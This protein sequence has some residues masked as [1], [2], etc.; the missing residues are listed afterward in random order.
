MSLLFSP[1]KIGNLEIK[2][3]FIHSAT[4]EGMAAE[5][6]TVQDAIIK[7]YARLAKGEVGLIIPGYLFIHPHG[8]ALKYQT[9]IHSDEMIPGLKKVVDAV[10]E[11]DGRIVFQIAHSGRQTTKELIGR[12]PKGPSAKWRNP[13]DFTRPLEMKEAEIHKTIRDFG[14]AARR[15]A[16]AGADGV[17]L[18]AAH[19]YLINQFLS[20]FYNDR[21]DD[22]GG[23]DENR[24]RFLK[25]VMAEVRSALPENMPVLIKLN[26]NDFTPR[27][28]IV[29]SLAATYARWLEDLK[30]DLVEVSCGSVDFAPFNECRGDI[31]VDEMAACF[32]WWKR[33]FV[34]ALLNKWVGKYDLEEGYNLEAAECIKP[35][36]GR[37]PMSVVG[38]IRRLNQMEEIITNKKSDFLSMSRP[39][40]R[41]PDIVRKFR[42]NK[43]NAVACISCN[44]CVAAILYHLPTRCY[45]KGLPL[46]K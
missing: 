23:S 26:S 40:I 2:N 20:P 18:H 45:Q 39:F 13:V 8:Q 15:A 4:Y 27:E 34:K 43:A 35:A 10:H 38:G 21:K 25:E 14:S 37:I 29:P 6:G 24:F 17:Q 1:A 30:I 19:G 22:W 5:D 41:E 12:K 9:G 28:G 44:R 32:P 46:S 36:L 3:R 31:P 16:E 33:P 42:Q 11:H 7:R